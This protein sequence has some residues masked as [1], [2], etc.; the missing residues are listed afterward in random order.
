MS[1]IK[2]AK[3]RPGADCGSDH[4]HLIAKFR[5]KWKKVGKTTRPFRYLGAAGR[6][7]TGRSTTSTARTSA[8]TS[9]SCS[10]TS[11]GSPAPTRPSWRPA[12]RCPA[13]RP[14]ASRG[15]SS[16]RPR[17]LPPPPRC[18]T[19]SRRC[20]PRGPGRSHRVS[21]VPPALSS[22]SGGALGRE[23][24]TAT[25]A[26]ISLVVSGKR[27]GAAVSRAYREVGAALASPPFPPAP[28]LD[29]AHGR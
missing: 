26:G 13:A 11:R 20:R 19:R 27:P 3:T 25:P 7:A 16:R 18:S 23:G 9:R 22:A 1:S 24:A 12:W 17:P 8:A 28:L 4:E 14:T 6:R 5:L 21:P 15:S 2:S 10:C 29:G